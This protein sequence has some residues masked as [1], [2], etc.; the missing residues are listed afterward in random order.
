MSYLIMPGSMSCLNEVKHFKLFQVFSFPVKWSDIAM[1]L[2][3]ILVICLTV[4]SPFTHQPYILIHSSWWPHWL[5][6]CTQCHSVHLRF[7]FPLGLFWQFLLH[8]IAVHLSPLWFSIDCFWEGSFSEGRMTKFEGR[9]G[10]VS[11]DTARLIL[12]AESRQ[13]SHQS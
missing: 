5:T 8:F 13:M 3:T 7:R 1:C 2:S 9:L 10:A 4:M 11:M 6:V 12:C